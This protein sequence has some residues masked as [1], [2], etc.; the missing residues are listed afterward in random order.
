MSFTGAMPG[1]VLAGVLAQISQI[2]AGPAVSSASGANFETV[3]Q[4]VGTPSATAT[5]GTGAGDS[6]GASAGAGTAEPGPEPA[7]VDLSGSFGWPLEEDQ[8]LSTPELAALGAAGTDEETSTSTTSSAVNGYVLDT[9]TGPMTSFDAIGDGTSSTALTNPLVGTSDTGQASSTVPGASVVADAQKYLGV[10]YLWG[11]TNPAVGLDCSGL[12]QKVFSDLGVNLP[13]TADEQSLVGTPVSSLSQAQPGDL[14]F[15][16]GSDGT[17]AD[18]GHVGIYVGNGQMI[19][20]PYS[21]T[22]VRQEAVSDAGP[23]V[24][25]RR[26][27]STPPLEGSAL[28]ASS[29]TGPTSLTGSTSLSGPVSA[30]T[31]YEAEFASASTAESLP[32]NLLKA[33]AQTESSM[34]PNA[35]SSA[36][37]QGLMQLMPSTAASLGVDPFDPSQAISGAAHLLSSLYQQFGSWPLAVAAYNAGAGAVNQYGGIPPYPQTQAYVQEVLTRAGMEA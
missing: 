1:D 23:V 5:S 10:P 7:N 8:L 26:V 19:D 24:A 18:P 9:G 28:D 6:T 29:P 13:R 33:V 35:V 30:P 25:I 16:A 14:V 36:G 15:F 31:S 3:M 21:G 27:L 20:A 12:V 4:Q 37:A 34:N 32:P 22:D 17:A 2:Q 11:G